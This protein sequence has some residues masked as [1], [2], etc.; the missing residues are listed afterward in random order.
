MAK[1]FPL[2]PAF[3][4]ALP[5]KVAGK[6]VFPFPVENRM[7]LPP[8]HDVQGMPSLLRFLKQFTAAQYLEAITDFHVLFFLAANDV[9]SLGVCSFN[10]SHLLSSA[11]LLYERKVYLLSCMS[12]RPVH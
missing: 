6:Q 4:L 12:I 8:R 11:A 3:T 2:E 1:G 7:P 5:P 9:V 10:S